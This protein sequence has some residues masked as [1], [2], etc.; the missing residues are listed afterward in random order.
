MASLQFRDFLGEFPILDVMR[1]PQ[2]AAQ[3]AE[4]I[5]LETGAVG[6]LKAPSAAHTIA[7]SG[8]MRSIYLLDDTWVYWTATINAVK[9][10]VASS[11]DLVLFT[12]DGY[13]KQT[14]K[15]YATSG[16]ASTYPTTT[17]RLGVTPPTTIPTITVMGTGDGVVQSSVAYLYTFVDEFG[18]ESAPYEATAVT[19][20]EGDEYVKLTNFSVPDVGDTGNDIEFVR[21]YRTNTANS[22]ETDYQ[23]IKARPGTLGATPVYDVPAASISGTSYEIF[24]AN[25]GSSP[26]GVTSDISD[27]L[28]SQ[29]EVGNTTVTW[30]KPV[31]TLTGLMEGPQKILAGHVGNTVYLGE[32]GVYYAFPSAYAITLDHDAVAIGQHNEQ[33]IVATEAHPY[34]LRGID[35]IS[36][37]KS[38]L[39]YK[40]PCLAARGL[41]NTP[42]GV[43]WPSYDGLVICD[44]ITCRVLTRHI[45]SKDDW[46][47]YTLA[48]MITV[49]WKGSI[50]MFFSGA[51]TGLVLDLEGEKGLVAL[52]IGYNVYDAFVAPSGTLYLLALDGADYKVF[53]WEGGTANLTAIWKSRTVKTPPMSWPLISVLG[54]FS[55]DG[56]TAEV[57]VYADGTLREEFTFTASGTK[58][59]GGGYRAEKWI[60]RWESATAEV[61]SIALATSGGEVKGV[62]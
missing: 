38:K 16:A 50:L 6:L 36:I 39:D 15:T 57:D 27:V 47:G 20:V 59:C 41:V 30:D 22:G 51:D 31:D 1:L 40:L 10:P 25:D 13:P 49:Y 46:S 58:R 45:I 55:A 28:P 8:A 60:V 5:N 11:D 56:A 52:D 54:D 26:T 2:M 23:L 44:G 19:D 61:L 17:R 37:V 48:N 53:E 9:A 7:K 4:N 62:S 33:F 14:N 21:I 12:G 43:V 35:P 18:N 29:Y 32:P 24:D 3:E 34:V 42:V